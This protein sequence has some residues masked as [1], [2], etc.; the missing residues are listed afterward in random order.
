MALFGLVK[1]GKKGKAILHTGCLLGKYDNKEL[2]ENYEEILDKLGIDFISPEKLGKPLIC[3][4]LALDLG[5]EKDFIKI[6]RRN[7]KMLKTLGIKRII[8]VCPE[9]FKALSQDYKEFIMDWNIEIEF[10]LEVIL[11]RLRKKKLKEDNALSLTYHDPSYLGR[12]C[13][14]YDTPRNILHVL[15]HSLTELKYS[16][17]DSFSSGSCGGLPETNPELADE[18]AKERLRQARDSKVNILVTSGIR[19][20]EHL[21]RNSSGFPEIRVFEI[22]E[23]ICHAL[24]IKQIG[25]RA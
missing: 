25:A 18:I 4:S 14:I 11:K 23:L 17:E 20:S 19:T 15:G 24:G 3:G 12:Y 13:G 10:A 16:R 8:A 2:R 7:L 9:C 1:G 5:Y 22:S 21:K 6:A